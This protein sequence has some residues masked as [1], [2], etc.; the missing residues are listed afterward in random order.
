MKETQGLFIFCH[1]ALKTIEKSPASNEFV[2]Q[3][4]NYALEQPW[5]QLSLIEL[6]AQHCQLNLAEIL[7]DHQLLFQFAERNKYHIDQKEFEPVFNQVLLNEVEPHLPKEPFFL[8]DFP[9]VLSPMAKTQQDRP[10]FAQR[11]ELYISGLEIANGCVEETDEKKLEQVFVQQL[12]QL[13]MGGQNFHCDT[14]FLQ[15]VKIN[16]KNNLAGVGLGI[17]RLAMILAGV[18]NVNQVSPNFI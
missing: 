16:A 18:I 4:T 13:Q 10:L 5:L 2:Y 1:Q 14:D 6:F 17:D 15:A 12:A 7:E 9:A 11:F 3:N 8:T